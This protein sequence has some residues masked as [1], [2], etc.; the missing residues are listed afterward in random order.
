MSRRYRNRRKHWKTDRPGG[1]LRLDPSRKKI[2]GV[3]AGIAN[4]FGCTSFTVRLLSI[5]ALF[6]MPHI[7]L[8]AYGLAYLI[9]DSEEGDELYDL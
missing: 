1:S 6:I 8:P 4:Y 9:L 2:G 3:C 5:V 7:T